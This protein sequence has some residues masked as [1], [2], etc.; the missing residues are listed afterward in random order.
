MK[1]IWARRRMLRIVLQN[2]QSCERVLPL[3]CLC[4]DHFVYFDVVKLADSAWVHTTMS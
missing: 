1:R 4:V 3:Q 2:P